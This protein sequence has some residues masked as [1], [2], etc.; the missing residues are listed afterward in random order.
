M[1]IR[2]K[3]RQNRQIVVPIRFT[4]AVDGPTQAD[5]PDVDDRGFAMGARPGT[6]GSTDA[7]GA[8]VSIREGDSIRVKV[9]REDIDSSA[10]LFVTSTNPKMVAISGSAA[11]GAD[12]VF[13][14]TGVSDS[15]NAPVMIQVHLGS[16][17]GPVLGELEPHIFQVRQVRVH[18]HL[19]SINPPA[20][21]PDAASTTSRTAQS[22]V[23]LF[24]GVNRIWRPVG[25]E[26]LY[27]P[28]HTTSGSISG[29]TTKGVMTTDIAHNKFSE[30][31]RVLTLADP[32]TGDMPDPNAVNIYFVRDSSEVQGLTF[33]NE[34]PQHG[35]VISDL[36]NDDPEQTTAHELGHY[37][38]DDLHADENAASAHIR[39][40]ISSIR[41]LLFGPAEPGEDPPYRSDVGY[42]DKLIGNLITVK[43][44]PADPND[45]EVDRNRRRALHPY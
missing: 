43:H 32:L 3:V 24:E 17:S 5:A 4:R 30:F 41:R 33:D 13:S 27:D 11:L 10:P 44:H 25:I 45:G 21:G 7:R 34:N 12:G 42:G 15:K 29:F 1:A 9:L 35:V 31:T 16:I 8:M 26:F 28:T 6:W 22:L 18:A 20:S 23:A 19:V 36:D 39:D 14:L 37:L 40:D 2:L 38:D